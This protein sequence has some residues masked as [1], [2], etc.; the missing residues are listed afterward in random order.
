MLLSYMNLELI[1][2]R[3]SMVYLV[4]FAIIEIDALQEEIPFR[5]RRDQKIHL[6]II[7]FLI[8]QLADGRAGI[9]EIIFISVG[10]P[11]GER[12]FH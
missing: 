7:C 2:F 1:S 4:G 8:R 6:I 3:F 9:G 10:L 11:A 12:V 5:A